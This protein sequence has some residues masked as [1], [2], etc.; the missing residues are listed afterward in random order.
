MSRGTIEIVALALSAALFVGTLVGVPMYVVRIP[1]DHFVRPPPPRGIA[2]KVLRNVLGSVLIALGVAMLVLPGQGLITILLGLS[3]LD[4]P[5]KHRVM[6]RILQQ[7]NLQKGIQSL[8]L[9]AGKEPLE[10]PTHPHPQDP[11][12]PEGGSGTL[13]GRRFTASS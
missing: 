4:L 1:A 9:R 7:P 3:I 10:I 11:R 12:K 2:A 6:A 5:I 13:E 8:R